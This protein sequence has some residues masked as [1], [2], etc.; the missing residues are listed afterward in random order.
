[1]GPTNHATHSTDG[2]GRVTRL[3]GYAA[4]FLIVGAIVYAAINV[5]LAGSLG[6][7]GGVPE[8]DLEASL[9]AGAIGAILLIALAAYRRAKNVRPDD[10]N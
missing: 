6:L 1:M 4:T 9:V 8:V 3:V 5:A 10:E 7:S 2:E